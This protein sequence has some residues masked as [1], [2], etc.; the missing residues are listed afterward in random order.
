MQ[1]KR[2]L[3][4]LAA[5]GL[6]MVLLGSTLS[7]A[8]DKKF[9]M[10]FVYFGSS[11]SYTSYVDRTQNSLNQISP[12]YFNL[13]SDGSL[14]L[15]S[16]LS[17]SFIDDMHLRGVEVLP[18]LSNHWDYAL[19]V[20][21]LNNRVALAY[22]IG[23]V[24]RAY[25][26]DGIVVDLEN[27]TSAERSAYVDFIR[28]LKEALPTGTQISVA[29][30]ANPYGTS[31]GWQGSYDYTGLAQYSDYLMIMAYDEHY[32]GGPAGPVASLSFVEKC[33]AYAVSKVPKEKVVVGL[34]FYG[35]I[36]SNAGGKPSG[37][38]ISNTKTEELIT[39]YNGKV[40]TDSASGTSYAVITVGQSDTKP[41]IGGTTLSAGTYTIWYSNEQTLKKML[42][43]VEKYDIKGTGSWSL[44]QE[45][46]N[47]W[48]YY[49]LWL[50]G[51]YFGDI[52][53]HWA[54]NA[55]F[56]AYQEGWVK[57]ATTTAYLPDAS[58]T[59]AEAAAMLVRM[60]GLSGTE[61]TDESFTDTLN[62]WAKKEIET[63]RKYGLIAGVGNNLFEPDSPITREQM[64]VILDK[65]LGLGYNA[66]LPDIFTD[67]NQQDNSWSYKAIVTMGQNGIF[68]GYPDGGFHPQ[69]TLTRGQMAVLLSTLKVYI[70]N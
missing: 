31:S 34:P 28:L 42:T 30:A 61:V 9:N 69:D 59:R 67:I 14:N 29:V 40:Y 50:N 3:K 12:S 66:E 21:A 43:L 17:Q 16:A 44:G 39:N 52:Q 68:K 15:S 36:W 10:S 11:S 48:S 7:G 4:A 22:Q 60:L 1:F 26:L 2:R 5:L 55:I 70:R 25:Q 35:R 8:A 23:E 37:Y 46:E 24:V 13:H 58:L 18:F 33:I 62:H 64:A 51:C 41:V 38:G 32:E 63:A 19:G 47:T 6:T 20:A 54:K 65:L 53:Y 49:N 56:S 57:G 45:T 27:L